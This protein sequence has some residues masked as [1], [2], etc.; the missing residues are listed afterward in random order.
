M[1]E[2][3][4]RLAAAEFLTFGGPV[5]DSMVSLCIYADDIDLAA[6]TERIGCRPT[7]ARRKGE[8]DPER[9]RIRPAQIGQWILEA[10]KELSFPD[11]TAFLLQATVADVEVWREI[12]QTHNIQLRCA[13]FLHSWTEGFDLSPETL[14]EIGN[15]GGRSR[16]LCTV[17]KGMRLLRRF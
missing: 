8:K 10:P 12:G 3:D 1:E 16:C 9:P 11:K 5:P 7:R 13:V 15:R 17:R 4:K 6:L 14:G 2:F